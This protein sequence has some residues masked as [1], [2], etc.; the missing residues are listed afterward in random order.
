M[1]AVDDYGLEA[2]WYDYAKEHLEPMLSQLH[3]DYI[4]PPL[5]LPHAFWER[6]NYPT[7][8]G[9]MLMLQEHG[10]EADSDTVVPWGRE[11]RYYGYIYL[12]HVTGYMNNLRNVLQMVKPPKIFDT[13][14]EKK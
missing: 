12:S 9:M 4:R 14:K 8:H 3:Y 2:T 6:R 5:R 1:R 10:F 13:L 11:A 7:R